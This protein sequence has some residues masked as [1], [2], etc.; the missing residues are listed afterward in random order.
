MAGEIRTVNDSI[1]VSHYGRGVHI[2]VAMYSSGDFITTT[3]IVEPST[4]R[5][6]ATALVETADDAEANAQA[7]EPPVATA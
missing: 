5:A 1:H 2:N 7:V 3:L 6:L 4:A